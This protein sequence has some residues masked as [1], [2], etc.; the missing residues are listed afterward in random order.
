M[1]STDS[2]ITFVI[3]TITKTSVLVPSVFL[4]VF[5]DT[6][7][8][9]LDKTLA[10][11]M[12][13]RGILNA[14]LLTDNYT[15]AAF[16]ELLKFSSLIYPLP[17]FLIFTMIVSEESNEIS[18]TTKSGSRS[19]IWSTFDDG[20]SPLGLFVIGPLSAK[21]IVANKKEIKITQQT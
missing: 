20:T 1:D 4:S 19:L 14:L 2:G 3:S 11:S 9:G 21:S 18:D 7:P 8:P 13:A 17:M 10:G 12:F 16:F 5:H 15:K 6:S